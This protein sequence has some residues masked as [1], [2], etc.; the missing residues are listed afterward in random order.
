MQARNLYEFSILP[1]AGTPGRV[2]TVAYID[3]VTGGFLYPGPGNRTGLCGQGQQ[4]ATA[5]FPGLSAGQARV[6]YTENADVGKAWAFTL[7]KNNVTLLSGYLDSRTGQ[8]SSFERVLRPQ[9]RAVNPK[10]GMNAARVIADQYILDQNGG[11]QPV[12]MSE[13]RYDALGSPGEPVSRHLYL[14]I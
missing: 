10:I 11:P 8:V 9:E 12:N 4:I 1:I 5:A 7:S 14:R 3:A 2:V 6:R 13:A